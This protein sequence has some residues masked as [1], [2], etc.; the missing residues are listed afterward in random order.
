MDGTI[1]KDVIDREGKPSPYSRSSNI[2]EDISSR[3]YP[4]L[5]KQLIKLDAHRAA[6]SQSQCAEN[7]PLVTLRKTS[8]RQ[9]AYR[10]KGDDVE[11]RLDQ[12]G[13]ME[14]KM[15]KRNPLHILPMRFRIEL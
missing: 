3:R 10:D 9:I 14:T 12:Y 6:G 1:G 15:L 8:S 4:V 7:W 5:A 11:H 2:H 13:W